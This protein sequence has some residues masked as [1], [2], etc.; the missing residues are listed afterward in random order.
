V[1]ASTPRWTRAS[2]NAC[3]QAGGDPLAE[4][5][6][7]AHR[8]QGVEHPDQGGGQ[9][10]D[11]PRRH[12]PAGPAAAQLH[13]ER[14]RAV[15]RGQPDH[16]QTARKEPTNTTR[17]RKR[18]KHQQ[19]D[20]GRPSAMHFD[21]VRPTRWRR[22][23]HTTHERGQA[24]EGEQPRTLHP[25]TRERGIPKPLFHHDDS[26]THRP[27]DSLYSSSTTRPTIAARAP[28]KPD[29]GWSIAYR[30]SRRRAAGAPAGRRDRGGYA[31]RGA[32]GLNGGRVTNG[33]DQECGGTQ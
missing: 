1:G 14:P 7:A 27:K 24:G 29:A 6:P 21:P 10:G 11:R 23:S 9:D 26:R 5:A 16:Q 31:L 8:D 22:R 17:W 32:S 33:E 18:R 12:R 3:D 30:L 13:P 2:A 28:P 15:H 20:H 19:R 4:L 25:H